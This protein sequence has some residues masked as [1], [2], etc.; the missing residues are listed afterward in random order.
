[1][2][3][4]VISIDSFRVEGIHEDQTTEFKT[5]IFVDAE[6]R[7]P[8]PR[9]MR[10]I[11]D[12][13]AAFMNAEGGMLL[14]G[15]ADDKTICGIEEDLR[16]L[17]RHPS[18]VIAQ[19]SRAS[20]SGHAY[21]G[22]TDKYE[23]K[24]RA[25]VKAYMSSNAYAYLGN[26]G[27]GMMGTRKVCRI[28]VKPTAGEDIVYVYHKPSSGG[29]ER[30]EI[31]VRSGNQ[32]LQLKGRARDEFVRRKTLAGLEAQ[33]MAVQESVAAVQGKAKG[34]VG[35]L[36]SV[37]ALLERLEGQRLVGAAVTVSGGHPFT[38]EAVTAAGRPKSLA[39]EGQ[40]YAEVSGWQELVLKVLEKLQELNAAKFD[41]LADEPAFSR[42]LVKVLR[43]REKHGDC[44][45]T[46]FGANGSIRIKKSLGNKVYLYQE[47]KVLRR[48]IAAFGVD[49]SRFMFVAG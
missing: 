11:A 44:Y 35:V 22:S 4:H 49:V 36:D 20:D 32:K 25:L 37:R 12:T 34:Y 40:H 8:G 28:D 33:F 38:E 7:Q 48:L 30:E 16:I 24:I 1:M 5:S 17:D 18:S 26:I 9:Q 42:H 27:F 19:S 6:T 15:V 29:P 43:P 31:F 2:S 41:E 21:G 39:W 10:V 47:D 13:L 46:K 14:V 23:L 45:T 3:E